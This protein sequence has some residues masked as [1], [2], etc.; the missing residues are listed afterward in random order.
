MNYAIF[1][2]I[3]NLVLL[4]R[5][6]LIFRDEGATAKDLAIIG[7]VPLVVLPF[8]QLSWGWGIL[9]LHLASYPFV[10]KLAE[11]SRDKLNRN[12]ALTLLYHLIITGIICSPLFEVNGGVLAEKTIG[13]L[14][15]MTLPEGDL[16]VDTVTTTQVVSAGMLLVINEM[17]IVL[18]YV[19]KIMGIE[20]L[21]MQEDKVR[22]EEYSMGRLIGLLERIFIFI[23]VLLNQYSAIGF[24]L[25]AKGVTRFNNFKDDRPFA[26]YVLIGTLLSTLLALIIGGGVKILL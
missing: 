26:E 13:F 25:A 16:A 6:R 17:N 5:L 18:R 4:A 21:G 23:F 3:L 7:I 19:L 10:M 8:V 11:H 15:W 14:G 9:A 24:I 12:R 1:L 20:S 2:S 22:D